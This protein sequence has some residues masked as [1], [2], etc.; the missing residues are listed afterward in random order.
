[1][2]NQQTGI[3]RSQPAPASRGDS[4]GVTQLDGTNGSSSAA[5]EGDKGDGGRGGG[6]GGRHERLVVG[7]GRRR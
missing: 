1:M 2:P 4:S 7:R 6:A 5:G 3:V